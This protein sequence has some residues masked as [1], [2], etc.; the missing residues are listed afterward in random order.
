MEFFACVLAACGFATLLWC[1]S[2]LLLFPAA[3][4]DM[5]V[6]W[7]MEGDCPELEFRARSYLWLCRAGFFDA[8]LV[9]TDCGMTA[10]A[11]KRAE[12]LAKDNSRIELTEWAAFTAAWDRTDTD[13]RDRTRDPERRRTDGDVPESR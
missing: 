1:I 3:S 11:R 9:L 13:E 12:M 2:A 6:V 5:M 7:R 8:R 10:D 4:A